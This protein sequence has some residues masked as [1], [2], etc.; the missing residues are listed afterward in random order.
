MQI[1]VPQESELAQDSAAGRL[2]EV[3]TI[4]E[5]RSERANYPSKSP[6]NY[7]CGGRI[8]AALQGFKFEWEAVLPWV[9][10]RWFWDL[11]GS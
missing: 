3:L 9:V 2:A 1:Y 10:L 4:V 5:N 7:A 11:W 8:W 6:P